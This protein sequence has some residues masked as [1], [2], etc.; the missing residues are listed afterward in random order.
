MH[1]DVSIFHSLAVPSH[2]ED[3]IYS[4]FGSRA[5]FKMGASW[6]SKL[7]LLNVSV[8]INCTVI[9]AD[10]ATTLIPSLDTSTHVA[11]AVNLAIVPT[12]KNR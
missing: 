2:D 4:I 5:T 11:S 9:S 7:L 8:F 1:V 12:K 6:P 10:P 3:R